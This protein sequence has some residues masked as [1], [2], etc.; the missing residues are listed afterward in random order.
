MY[1]HHLNYKSNHIIQQTNQRWKQHE[2]I[3]EGPII[4]NGNLGVETYHFINIRNDH[5]IVIKKLN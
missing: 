5:D 1:C 4:L 3:S 2:K